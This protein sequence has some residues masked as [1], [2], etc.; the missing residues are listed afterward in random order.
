MLY[1]VQILL[2][3][4][5]DA[6]ATKSFELEEQVLTTA[7][8]VFNPVVY[9]INR[10]TGLC[11][12]K[13]DW[14]LDAGQGNDPLFSGTFQQTVIDDDVNAGDQ[15]PYD[16]QGNNLNNYTD[17]V[18]SRHSIYIENKSATTQIYWV[19]LV[20]RADIRAQLAASEEII[21]E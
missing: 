4:Q 9:L 5:V 13:I 19:L 3:F 16:F 6:G 12:F 20:G 18:D 10:S 8:T 11:H 14:C 17:P 1:P 7:K 21:K 2:P 15:L